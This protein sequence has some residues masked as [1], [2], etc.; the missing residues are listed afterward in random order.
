M[1]TTLELSEDSCNSLGDGAVCSAW[2]CCSELVC[3]MVVVIYAPQKGSP[4]APVAMQGDAVL[5]YGF[6]PYRHG[7]S[8]RRCA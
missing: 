1:R 7:P 2:P 6:S 5:G 4:P 8:C 3:S